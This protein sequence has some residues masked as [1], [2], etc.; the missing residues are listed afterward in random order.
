M[1][2][3]MRM[4]S[5]GQ[6]V[7]HTGKPEWGSGLITEAMKTTQDG[8]PCQRL[9]IRFDRAG[10]KTIST[11]F[12]NLIPAEDAAPLAADPID[13]PRAGGSN[14]GPTTRGDSGARVG[15]GGGSGGQSEKEAEFAA[16]LMGAPASLEIRQRMTRLPEPATDPFLTVVDRLK[17]TIGLY[18]FQPTGAS[19]LDWAAMQSGLSDPMSRFNRHELEKFFESFAIAR[20]QHLKKVAADAR[21]LEPEKTMALLKAAPS[22]VQQV[23]RRFDAMR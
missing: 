12:A 16:R 23:L 3:T 18:R 19:L 5:T 1:I 22:I 13:L 10:L 8:K 15:V 9:T 7:L 21:K 2:Q 4:F 6:R 14:D 17:N 20:D 11:A